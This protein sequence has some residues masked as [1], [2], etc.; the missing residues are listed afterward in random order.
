MLFQ[1]PKA[2]K[3]RAVAKSSLLFGWDLSLEAHVI[4]WRENEGDINPPLVPAPGR[5]EE[6]ASEQGVSP[7]PSPKTMS[8]K[9][10]GSGVSFSV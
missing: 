8:R 2:A 5:Q 7:Y 1:F 10:Y 4:P 9:M 3:R 6:P